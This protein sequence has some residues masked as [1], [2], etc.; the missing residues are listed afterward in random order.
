MGVVRDPLVQPRGRCQCST[1]RGTQTRLAP[2]SARRVVVRRMI[3]PGRKSCQRRG[4]AVV[5]ADLCT[6]CWS[7]L[8]RTAAMSLPVTHLSQVYM[9]GGPD[10]H[11]MQPEP[12]SALICAKRVTGSD[13]RTAVA[14]RTRGSETDPSWIGRHRA[15]TDRP[16]ACPR[17]FVR[18]VRVRRASEPAARRPMTQTAR[19]RRRRPPGPWPEPQ[20]FG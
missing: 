9:V 19:V 13:T 5:R 18:D 10:R 20:L 3:R 12:A 17:S 2:E 7:P 6:R 1:P 14:W 8:A 11:G 4:V 16:G 15:Q